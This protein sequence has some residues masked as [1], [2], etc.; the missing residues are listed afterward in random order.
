MTSSSIAQSASDIRE[1]AAVSSASQA[2]YEHRV[3]AI[4]FGVT[5]AVCAGFIALIVAEIF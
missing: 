5:I 2:S 3:A 1:S 4:M